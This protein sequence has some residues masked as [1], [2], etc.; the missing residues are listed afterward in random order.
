MASL[1]PGPDPQGPR[2]DSESLLRSRKRNFSEAEVSALLRGV[3]SRRKK[4]LAA[5]ED[6]V[7]LWQRTQIW[8][9]VTEAVNTASGFRN[10]R[11]PGEVKKKWSDIKIEA[12]KRQRLATERGDEGELRPMH[13]RILAILQRDQDLDC[14]I[15]LDQDQDCPITG[16]CPVRV[17]QEPGLHSGL[18]SVLDSGLD[19]GLALPTIVH[20]TTLKSEP[21]L[22]EFDPSSMSTSASTEHAQ[23]NL[24][25]ERSHH[26]NH[27]TEHAENN[28]ATEHA[29]MNH[30]TERSH[31]GNHTTEHAQNNHDT[32]RSHHGNNVTEHAQNNHTTEHAQSA[33][34][35]L[36]LLLVQN[37][38]QILDTLRD[39]AQTFSQI[40]S[41][42]KDIAHSLKNS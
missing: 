39:M 19:S 23:N 34:P 12:R 25:T 4:L 24:F 26:G 36:M 5:P 31:H 28:H 10:R 8:K 38:Q 3:S 29:Q 30:V 35:D 13:K 14:T 27:A 7:P 16:D 18:D 37:Q 20:V 41:S 21:L 22:S 2:A 40:N 32:E 1:S 15:D 11:T 42:L 6:K 33:R 9:Q 17:K